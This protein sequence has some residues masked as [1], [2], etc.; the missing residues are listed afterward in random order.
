MAII[1]DDGDLLPAIY[2][3]PFETPMWQTLLSGLRRQT[4]ADFASLTLDM[5]SAGITRLSSGGLAGLPPEWLQGLRDERV[6]S[7]EDL[8]PSNAVL[9]HVDARIIRVTEAG[10]ARATIALTRTRGR[11]SAPDGA[12]LRRIAPHLRRSLRAY[13]EIERQ[14][15]GSA[16]VADVMARLDF[17][18]LKVDARASVIE[19]SNEATRLLQHGAG[20]RITSRGQLIAEDP[21]VGRRLS[22]ALR[23]VID[24]RSDQPRAVNVSHE[25]WV[26]LLLMPAGNHATIYIQGDRR[27]LADRHEQLA[28]LFGLLPSEA[29]LALALSRG[30]TIAEAADTLGLTIETARNYSKKIYAKMGAR[31]QSDVVRY[32]LTSVLALA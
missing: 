22:A 29:R 8:D 9:P 15:A 25:P 5:G 18:W 1:E 13:A 14:K 16:V 17:G 3:G 28:E 32:I 2:D 30:M 23:A 11:F 20:L 21:A 31:G 19:S 27:S 24:G 10:G 12:L 6:Y 26:D 4:G 7:P